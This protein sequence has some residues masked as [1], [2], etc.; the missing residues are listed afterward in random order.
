[1]NDLLAALDTYWLGSGLALQPGAGLAQ[2]AATDAHLGLS[3]PE[4]LRCFYQH[5]DGSGHG[6]DGAMCANH[7]RFWSSAALETQVI[8]GHRLVLFADFLIDSHE[9][10]IDL[11]TGAVVLVGGRS[12]LAVAPGFADFLRL[13]L[14]GSP[15]LHGAASHAP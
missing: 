7:F 8:A 11:A 15:R 9:Y 10:A 12:F 14:E 13:Y 5:R 3:L 2:L 1:V 4:A 6:R